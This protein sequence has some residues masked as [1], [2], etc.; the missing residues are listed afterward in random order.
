MS[1]DE[2]IAV[3]I[4]VLLLTGMLESWTKI[5]RRRGRETFHVDGEKTRFDAFST[6]SLKLLLVTLKTTSACGLVLSLNNTDAAAPMPPTD[7]SA[8]LTEVFV[9]II[10]ATSTFITAKVCGERQIPLPR[11][12]IADV[13]LTLINALNKL[14]QP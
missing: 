9:D 2:A 14:R 11:S 10:P 3:T 12:G 8:R 13:A 4:A 1:T 5:L 6:T 7:R